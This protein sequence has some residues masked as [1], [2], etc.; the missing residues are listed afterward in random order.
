MTLPVRQRKSIGRI[1]GFSL[2]ATQKET[3]SHEI[4]FQTVTAL[5]LALAVS[6]VAQAQA[7]KNLNDEISQSDKAARVFRE[8]MDTPDKGIPEGLV[9]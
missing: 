9:G 2:H 1:D 3:T 5:C 7:Q 6:A 8:I 4:T